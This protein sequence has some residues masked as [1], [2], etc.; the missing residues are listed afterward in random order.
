M[1]PDGR[2][3]GSRATHVGARQRWFDGGGRI[4]VGSHGDPGRAGCG[5][6]QRLET[7]QKR[8]AEYWRRT[9][10]GD[11]IKLPDLPEQ[12]AVRWFGTVSCVHS[13]NL[14]DRGDKR[15]AYATASHARARKRPGHR[16]GGLSH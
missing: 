12:A 10:R 3:A 14:L 11:T 5:G 7:G 16:G 6:R 15:L 2:W 4:P 13:A 1:Q 9:G 8:I